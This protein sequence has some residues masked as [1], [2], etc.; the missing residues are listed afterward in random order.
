M[1]RRFWKV[2]SEPELNPNIE[3]MVKELELYNK[4]IDVYKPI[5]RRMSL[6]YL[7]SEAENVAKEFDYLGTAD[8]EEKE[9]SE[10]LKQL[11]SL[12]NRFK[13]YLCG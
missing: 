4:T 2:I 1:A 9:R 5:R 7:T 3:N 11:R 12:I 13:G 10:R 8:W 6:P